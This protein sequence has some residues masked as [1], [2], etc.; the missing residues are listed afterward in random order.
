MV[1]ALSDFNRILGG[2]KV[3]RDLGLT[4]NGSFPLVFFYLCFFG[5]LWSCR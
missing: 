5:L 3:V 4:S 2:L 1:C